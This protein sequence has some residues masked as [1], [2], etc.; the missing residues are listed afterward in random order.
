[1]TRVLVSPKSAKRTKGLQENRMLNL[2]LAIELSDS[3]FAPHGPKKIRTRLLDKPLAQLFWVL[4]ALVHLDPPS[5]SIVSLVC[6]NAQDSP[7]VT[8]R[9]P[10]VLSQQLDVRTGYVYC[11]LLHIVHIVGV[12]LQLVRKYAHPPAPIPSAPSSGHTFSIH[13]SAVV[14][15]PTENV[16][17]P[18]CAPRAGLMDRRPWL[19]VT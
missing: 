9:A 16:Q 10:K 5:S 3:L 17:R 6:L 8:V 15:F 12:I 14:V 7:D 19:S 4:M 18:H 2:L 11:I 1:M 13:A